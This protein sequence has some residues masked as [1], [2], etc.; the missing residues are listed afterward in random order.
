MREDGTHQVGRHKLV[1]I[2]IS[3]VRT[4]GHTSA[5][6]ATTRPAIG[7]G[8]PNRVEAGSWRCSKRRQEAIA[9]PGSLTR[10]V[11]TSHAKDWVIRPNKHSIATGSGKEG[12]RSEGVRRERV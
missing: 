12:R 2:R 8:G 7:E 9:T 10:I 11:S 5:R 4:A 6:E 1:V 3:Q